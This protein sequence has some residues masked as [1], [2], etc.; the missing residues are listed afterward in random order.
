MAQ[1]LRSLR[2]VT[3]PHIVALVMLVVGLLGGGVAFTLFVSKQFYEALGTLLF[4]ICVLLIGVADLLLQLI[5]LAARIH[6]TAV[7]VK[8]E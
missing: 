3:P 5:M 1:D 8:S 2:G 6:A 7:E 4:T